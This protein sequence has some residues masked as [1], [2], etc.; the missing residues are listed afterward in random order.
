MEGP[1]RPRPMD[2][3][4]APFSPEV[5]TA[6]LVAAMH[7]LLGERGL[8][9]PC[10]SSPPS[11]PHPQGQLGGPR[12]PGR[13]AWGRSAL[14]LEPKCKHGVPWAEATASSG[15]RPGSPRAEPL[16]QTQPQHPAGT[17]DSVLDPAHS[18]CRRERP[19][20]APGAQQP[21]LDVP[22]G[23]W[24]FLRR[25]GM[26]YQGPRVILFIYQGNLN[27]NVQCTVQPAPGD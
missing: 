15:S 4:H 7:R 13:A 23:D 27:A 18:A 26:Y 1:V 2:D 16:R 20:R 3:G 14:G 25:H 10:S 24:L 21:V 11:V 5:R 17:P 22:Q 19:S 6:G 8:G 12:A 9:V